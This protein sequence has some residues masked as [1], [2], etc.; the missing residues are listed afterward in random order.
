MPKIVN[1]IQE[2]VNYELKNNNSFSVPERLV[3]YAIKQNVPEES[4]YNTW[5]DQLYKEATVELNTILKDNGIKELE[6]Y[7]K[8][9]TNTLL[10]SDLLQGLD[11]FDHSYGPTSFSQVSRIKVVAQNIYNQAIS[12][13]KN[14][15]TNC[16]SL[17]SNSQL[18]MQTRALNLEYLSNNADLQEKLTAYGNYDSQIIDVAVL[19]KNTSENTVLSLV[20]IKKS[21]NEYILLDPNY[22]GVPEYKGKTPQEAVNNY[23]NSLDMPNSKAIVNLD[24]GKT[25]IKKDYPSDGII[26]KVMN[27]WAGISI[28][29]AVF[30]MFA[31]K[32]PI[33]KK[34]AISGLGPIFYYAGDS[35][36]SL[37]NRFKTKSFDPKD[38]KIHLDIAQIILALS[39][40]RKVTPT[41][42]KMFA[43]GNLL[44]LEGMARTVAEETNRYV[45]QGNYK[46]ATQALITGIYSMALT[47]VFIKGKKQVSF[48]EKFLTYKSNIVSTTGKFKKVISGKVAARE[49]VQVMATKMKA[50]KF[51]FDKYMRDLASDSKIKYRECMRDIGIGENIQIG[52]KEGMQISRGNKFKIPQD[53]IGKYETDPAGTK[54]LW[55]IDKKGL[56]IV[57]ELN[58]FTASERGYVSHTNLTGGG[59]AYSGGE[60]WFISE[61]KVRINAGSGAYGKSWK[62]RDKEHLTQYEYNKAIEFWKGLGYEVEVEPLKNFEKR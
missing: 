59:K 8:A 24:N 36:N 26:P 27:Y 4:A 28:G 20:L 55:V 21:N 30:S 29:A 22:R 12:E 60:V 40:R 32:E 58:E 57:R 2:E 50:T 11:S 51:S 53:H 45:K 38:P 18:L 37:Y 1:Y 47:L 7:V 6:K 54:Y 34:I 62:N 52:A 48:K 49:I 33:S 31:P 9:D 44:L 56:K 10:Y 61:N 35:I 39:I 15:D 23:L 42:M 16:N 14:F 13:I 43:G 3:L 5:H 19:N 41:S 25:T 17:F 46:K